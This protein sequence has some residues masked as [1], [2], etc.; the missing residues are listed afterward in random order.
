MPTNIQHFDLSGRRAVVVGADSVAGA[1]IT[2][3]FREADATVVAATDVST[4]AEGG[5]AVERARDELGG[6]EIAVCA[7]DLFMARPIAETTGKEVTRLAEANFLIPFAVASAAASALEAS[8]SSSTDATF[9]GGGRLILV[10]HILGE[11]GVANTSAY[12]AMHAGVQSLVRT[13]AQELG[14]Q[15]TV[16]NGIALGWME[17]M[18]DRLDPEDEEAMRATRFPVMKRTGTADEVGPMAV[19]LAGSGVGYVN[20]QVFTIDGG[21]LQHL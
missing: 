6:L 21:L 16:V 18:Q 11:R 3:A 2:E 19:W 15:G 14:P 9:G 17:W 1:A 4:A 5:T 7:T 12:A 13:L 20:G 10:S 8:D